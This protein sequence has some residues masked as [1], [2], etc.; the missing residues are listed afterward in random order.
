MNKL[1]LLE[2]KFGLFWS[3]K[4]FKAELSF[5]SFAIIKS[6]VLECISYHLIYG[7]LF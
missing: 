1:N 7:R 5:I 2:K 3:G 4:E 6:M